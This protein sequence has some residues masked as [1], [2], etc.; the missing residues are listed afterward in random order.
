MLAEGLDGLGL[1]VMGM[2]VGSRIGTIVTVGRTSAERSETERLASLGRHLAGHTVKLSERRGFLR[3]S[4]HLYNNEADVERVL[5][6]VSGW[7]RSE[8]QTYE[9]QSLMRSS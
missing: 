4:V 3:F 8:E 6:L 1:P 7:Q 2:P 5:E 9:L